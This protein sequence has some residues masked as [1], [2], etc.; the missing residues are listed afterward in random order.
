MKTGSLLFLMIAATLVVT[1][2]RPAHAWSRPEFNFAAGSTFGADGSPG[3]GGAAASITPMWP[4]GERVRFGVSLFADDIGTELGQL[5][6]PNDHTDLGTGALRHRWVWGAAWRGDADIAR[7][8]R[9][10][11]SLSGTWGWSRIEDDSRGAPLTAAS[12]V[13]VGLGG[14]VRRSVAPGQTLGLVVR[15]Q[16]LFA[17]R[18]ASYRRVERYTSAAVEWGWAGAR[19]P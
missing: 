17:E 3:E 13:G 16:R 2:S 15:W 9:W 18:N 8:G 11:A 5:Y 12:A 7:R 14:G 19:R 4:V 10:A 6:D 1:A